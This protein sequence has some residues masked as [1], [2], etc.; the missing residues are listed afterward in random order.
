MSTI[1]L[2]GALANLFVGSAT[3]PVPIECGLDA[4]HELPHRDLTEDA[5]WFDDD[6]ADDPGTD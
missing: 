3:E 4:G 1:A 5:V 6:G 2:C